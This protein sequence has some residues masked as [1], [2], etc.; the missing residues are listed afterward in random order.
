MGVTNN[1]DFNNKRNRESKPFYIRWYAN[2]FAFSR[3]VKPI[4]RWLRRGDR[5]K[6]IHGAK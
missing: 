3:Y 5:G 2:Q 4:R 1:F 6:M